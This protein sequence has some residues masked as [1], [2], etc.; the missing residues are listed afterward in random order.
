MVGT[1]GMG[2]AG[3]RRAM[4]ARWSLILLCF[5]VAGAIGGGLFEHMVL[6][7]LWSAAPPASFS[8]IQPGT[9]VPLQTFW[10]P[11]HGAITVFLILS[12]VLAWRDVRTRRWLLVALASYVVMRAWSFAYFVPEMLAFQEVPTDGA[13]TPELLARVESWT[14]WTLFREP[15]DVLTFLS[16]LLGLYWL[17]R[18]PFQ[19]GTPVRT[20][21]VRPG[22]G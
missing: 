8:V 10:L 2:T 6:Q 21:G 4:M 5:S 1:V 7:P 15:L 20:G 19:Q 13:P 22:A 11:V 18:Q 9:G 16:C 17:N 12:L 3:S 14:F